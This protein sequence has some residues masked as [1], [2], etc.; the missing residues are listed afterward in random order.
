VSSEHI[1]KAYDEYLNILV[2][3]ACGMA[4]E[5]HAAGAAPPTTA[6]KTA[7]EAAL[8]AEVAAF[9]SQLGFASHSTNFEYD[10]FA[11]SKAS[12]RVDGSIDAGSGGSGGSGSGP[13]GAAQRKSQ[14]QQPMPR[15]DTTQQQKPGKLQQQQ[16]NQEQP[17]SSK[18]ATRHKQEAEQSPASDEQRKEDAIRTRTWVD[19]VGPRPGVCVCVCACVSLLLH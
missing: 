14:K 7:D 17:R 11:P 10:D 6:N 18:G 1:I 5:K 19:S 9:A 8:R 16:Q 12:R 4:K 15:N 2:I 3:G 13:G